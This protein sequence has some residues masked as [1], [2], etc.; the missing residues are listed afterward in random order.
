MPPDHCAVVG[1]SSATKWRSDESNKIPPARESVKVVP[2]DPSHGTHPLGLALHKVLGGLSPQESKP[3][4]AIRQVGPLVMSIV[5][6]MQGIRQPHHGREQLVVDEQAAD[7]GNFMPSK[8]NRPNLATELYHCSCTV[9]RQR[10]NSTSQKRGVVFF[11][12]L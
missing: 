10:P 9:W 6:F 7:F 4:Q 3:W 8:L 1:P 2:P 11:E 5:A 12:M